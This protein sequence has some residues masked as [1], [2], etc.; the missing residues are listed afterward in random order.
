LVVETH[1]GAGKILGVKIRNAGIKKRTYS[2]GNSPRA[3]EHNKE[4]FPQAPV[5]KVSDDA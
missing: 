1:L 5:G 2:F 4:V 3:K